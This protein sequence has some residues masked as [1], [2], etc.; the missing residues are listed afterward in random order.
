[1]FAKKNTHQSAQTPI[2]HSQLKNEE[3]QMQ[4]AAADDA[5]GGLRS[6]DQLP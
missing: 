4:A 3:S 2:I 5:L 1:L 6:I